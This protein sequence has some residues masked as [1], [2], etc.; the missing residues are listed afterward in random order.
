VNPLFVQLVFLSLPN[1][2]QFQ[3][4][5]A[6]S[7]ELPANHWHLVYELVWKCRVNFPPFCT[8][9]GKSGVGLPSIISSFLSWNVREE[10]GTFIRSLIIHCDISIREYAYHDHITINYT[11]TTVQGRITHQNSVRRYTWT[12]RQR[13]SA[14]SKRH[15]QIGRTRLCSAPFV[16]RS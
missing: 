1:S 16:N 7:S 3:Q 12:A 8:K 13:H 14:V 11:G 6:L 5:T 10:N 2:K 15:R 9:F 4:K